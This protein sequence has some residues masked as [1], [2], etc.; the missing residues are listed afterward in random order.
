MYGKCNVFEA[1]MAYNCADYFSTRTHYI[2]DRA[3][4]PSIGLVE[5]SLFNRLTPTFVK[6]TGNSLD[7]SATSRTQP[8]SVNA[9]NNHSLNDQDITSYDVS[10]PFTEVPSDETIGHITEEIYTRNEL[11]DLDPKLIS[12]VN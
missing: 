10:C 7:N 3:H 6:V 2:Q 8:T 1:W 4:S 5:K 11:Y 12:N 9:L